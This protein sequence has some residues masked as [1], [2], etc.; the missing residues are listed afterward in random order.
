MEM[1][2]QMLRT[3]C[4]LFAVL[5]V[6][7]LLPAAGQAQTGGTCQTFNATGQTVCGL[8]LSYWN[9]HGGLNQQG[10]PISAPF[11]EKSD[12]DGQMHTV[13]YFER[14]VFEYHPD[15]AGTP[16]EVELSLVGWQTYQRKYPNGAPNQRPNQDPGTVYFPQTQKR[17]GGSFRAYW[18][19]HGGLAQQGYPVS[20]EFTE[21]S[22]LD[23]KPYTVQ[24]FE[25]AVFEWHLENKGTPYEVLLAQLGTYE[26]RRKYE[27]PPPPPPPP[28]SPTNTPLPT[29]TPTPSGP[30]GIGVKVPLA[31]GVTIA[32]SNRSGVE[33][34]NCGTFMRWEFTIDNTTLNAFPVNVDRREVVQVDNNNQFYDRERQEPGSSCLGEAAGVGGVFAGDHR[35][36][37]HTA[38]QAW[39]LIALQPDPPGQGAVTFDAFMTVSGVALQFRHPIRPVP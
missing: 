10:Y 25:R 7:S 22:P 19:S 26:H 1:R 16:Y 18:E 36:L 4:T 27:A 12:T 37:R 17:L 5:M 29:A 24:Y 6:V 20:D 21:I 8:F 3:A 33:R 34:N 38:S 30:A 2:N 31:E 14:A 39:L 28:A 15:H 35:V 23:N 32:L 9:N 11:V 13:Q